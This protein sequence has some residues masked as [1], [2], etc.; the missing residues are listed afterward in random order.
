M[1]LPK[2]AVCLLHVT[3]NFIGMKN[4]PDKQITKH[5]KTAQGTSAM[6]CLHSRITM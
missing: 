2:R 4:F 1:K 5:L 3:V 6:A